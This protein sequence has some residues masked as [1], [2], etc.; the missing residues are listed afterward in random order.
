MSDA[1]HAYEDQIA[2]A[3]G[4]LKERAELRGLVGA[5]TEAVVLHAFLIEWASLSIQLQEPAERFLVEGSRRCS[6][7]GEHRLSITMLQ[8]ASEAIDRYRLVAD[9]TRRLAQLW[10]GRRRSLLNLTNLLTQSPTPSMRRLHNYSQSLVAGPQPWAQLAVIYETDAML[11]SVVERVV[12]QARRLLGDDVDSC[13]SSLD[14][15]ANFSERG[16]LG[17]TMVAFLDANP[18]RVDRMVETGC[19]TLEIY[20]DFLQECYDAASH[21]TQPER[22]AAP[23]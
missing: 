9:D 5:D 14:A 19:H 1:L 21:L 16:T 23:G 8:I 17:R 4:R 6:E 15:I 18:E 20:G 12:G 2:A 10:N 7:V 3:R 13:L 11:G 22:Q